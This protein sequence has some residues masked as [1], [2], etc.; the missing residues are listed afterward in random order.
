MG[1]RVVIVVRPE[2]GLVMRAGLGISIAVGTD[3]KLAVEFG[4]CGLK[5]KQCSQ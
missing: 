4:F 2:I 3:T 1:L 5:F